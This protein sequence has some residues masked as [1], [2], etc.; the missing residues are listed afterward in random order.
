[1][2]S[3]PTTQCETASDI[4]S[5]F[6]DCELINH[7]TTMRCRITSSVVRHSILI[8]VTLFIAHEYKAQRVTPYAGWSLTLFL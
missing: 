6:V 3:P 8:G 1:M 5:R 7:W 2:A 4:R